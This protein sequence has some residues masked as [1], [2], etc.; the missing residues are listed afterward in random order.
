MSHTYTKKNLIASK[1]AI[2][3]SS[4]FLFKNDHKTILCKNMNSLAKDCNILLMGQSVQ[5]LCL[6]KFSLLIDT[7]G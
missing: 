6:I 3:M 7:L 5:T 2:Y 4:F 1:K